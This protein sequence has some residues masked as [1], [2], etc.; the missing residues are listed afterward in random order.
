ML[1]LAVTLHNIP[2]G[3]AVGVTFAGVLADNTAMTLAGA[4]ALSAGNCHSELP[5]GAIHLHCR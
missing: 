1:V 4:F 3:M 5:E 2:E